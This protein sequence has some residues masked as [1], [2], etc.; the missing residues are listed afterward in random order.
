MKTLILGFHYWTWTTQYLLDEVTPYCQTNC[1]VVV[2]FNFLRRQKSIFFGVHHHWVGTF[3]VRNIFPY[4][5]FQWYIV[6]SSILNEKT[7]SMK[8]YARSL[9]DYCEETHIVKNDEI[10]SG[11]DEATWWW[12][13]MTIFQLKILVEVTNESMIWGKSLE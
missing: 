13:Q 9:E 1:R 10:D 11:L 8:I 4:F 7:L 5:Y 6:E 12:I 3:K 2:E